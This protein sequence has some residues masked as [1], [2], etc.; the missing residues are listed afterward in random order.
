[1]AV[2]VS[3]GVDGDRFEV[4]DLRR[5]EGVGGHAA[6]AAI[7]LSDGQRDLFAHVRARR[8]PDNAADSAI[9]PLGRAGLLAIAWVMLDVP[10]IWRRA[11]ANSS[12]V[13]AAAVPG[14][15]CGRRVTGGR[16]CRG[17]GVRRGRT[18]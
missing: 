16:L 12:P 17:R 9:S 5:D 4:Q 8:P 18:V 15:M 11:V 13:L 7:A 10:P 1:V 3:A 6:V 2:R 14:S